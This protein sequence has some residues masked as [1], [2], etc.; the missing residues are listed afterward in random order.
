MQDFNE[1]KLKITKEI[2]ATTVGHIKRSD[3]LQSCMC[4]RS[5]LRKNMRKENVKRMGG[6]CLV[7]VQVDS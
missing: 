7:Q 6:D 4:R 5:M 2:K 3:Q 1:K